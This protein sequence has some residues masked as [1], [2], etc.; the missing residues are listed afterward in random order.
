MISYGWISYSD[1]VTHKN[2]PDDVVRYLLT[3]AETIAVV[4][5]S[6]K[7]ERSSHGIMRRLLSLGYRV[8]PVTPNE[9]E[10]LGQRAYASVR[11]VPFPIDIVDVFRRADAVL[12]I[13]DD[14]IAAGAKVL[15]LQQG[16]I[17][18]EAAE[19]ARNAGL[20]VLMDSCIAVMH[21]TLAVPKK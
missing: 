19:R 15:W 18:E 12:P 8:V 3:R 17:N 4:G 6:S 11:D 1:R 9:N 7:P 20:T 14:A 10:V 16:V 21:S 5:A 2:P 13:A